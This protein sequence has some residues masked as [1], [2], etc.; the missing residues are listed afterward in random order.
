[1]HDGRFANLEQVIDHYSSGI[2]LHPNLRA[3]LL[4]SNGQ[5][6]QFNFNEEEKQALIAFL[7]TLTDHEMLADEKYSDPFN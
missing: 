1:M 6:F 3:P 5:A 7:N 2:Q 4:D